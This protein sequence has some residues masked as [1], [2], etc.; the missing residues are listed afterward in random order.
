[1][2]INIPDL[3]TRIVDGAVQ[4][5]EDSEPGME[6]GDL[7]AALSVAFSLLTEAQL[8]IFEK[9]PTIQTIIN[10]GIPQ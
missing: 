2:A 6:I 1:M 9:D 3:A 5:A 4:H 7:E 8:E 10:G